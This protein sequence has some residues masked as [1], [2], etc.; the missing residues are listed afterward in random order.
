MFN[1]NVTVRVAMEDSE[2]EMFGLDLKN[3]GRDDGLFFEALTGKIGAGTALITLE[4]PRTRNLMP[5]VCKRNGTHQF[6]RM[7]DHEDDTQAVFTLRVPI[8]EGSSGLYTKYPENNFHCVLFGENGAFEVWQVAIVSQEGPL[9]FTAQLL[10]AGQGFRG[11]DGM[12]VFPDPKFAHWEGLA[13]HLREI[14][15]RR[16]LL[17]LSAYQPESE[18]LAQAARDP[19]KDGEGEVVWFN[20]AMGT[21]L[22][23]TAKGP[24]KV[25]WSKIDPTPFGGSA[26]GYLTGGMRISYG[27]RVPVEE[28]LGRQESMAEVVR[29]LRKERREKPRSTFLYQVEGVQILG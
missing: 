3:L 8:R 19:L 29:N 16:K 26:P 28:N 18:A 14:M 5:F 23:E 9:W 11:E 22:I 12:I 27:A 7:R 15:Y 24:A 21:G 13:Q 20:L 25:H 10:Y 2:V 17:S 1:G 6:T 4:I